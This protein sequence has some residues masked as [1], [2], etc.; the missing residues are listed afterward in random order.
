[1]HRIIALFAALTALM[2]TGFAQ[3]EPFREG[4]HYRTLD[5]QVD[6]EDPDRIEVREFFFYGCPHCHNVQPVINQWEQNKGDDVNFVR[7]PVMFNRN[8]EPLARAFYVAKTE[9]ILDEV[10]MAIFQALH[11][12]NENLFDPSNLADFFTA[13]GMTREEFNELYQ[14]FGISTRVRQADAKTRQYQ[15]SGT[16]SFA[17]NGKYVVLRRN[18]ANDRET[19]EVIDYLVERERN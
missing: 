5:S 11:D 8:A 19:F 17:V 4:Q 13:Y 6:V 1:M 16:P 3:A 7:T 12:H 2:I 10:H 18:L 14:S 15:V 9:G